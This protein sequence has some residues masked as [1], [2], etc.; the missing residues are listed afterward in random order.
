MVQKVTGPLSN[1]TSPGKRP[2]SLRLHLAHSAT[3][4][5]NTAHMFWKPSSH[6]SGDYSPLEDQKSGNVDV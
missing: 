4:L 1:D 6:Q 3:M 2:V 5:E